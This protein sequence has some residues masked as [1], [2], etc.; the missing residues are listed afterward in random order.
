MENFLLLINAFFVW[1]F[2]KSSKEAFE[3]ERNGA[4]WIDLIL[5][6]LNFAI[7][8]NSLL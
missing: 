8:M 3:E 6:A 7:I 5:S 4:G 2:W 1:F